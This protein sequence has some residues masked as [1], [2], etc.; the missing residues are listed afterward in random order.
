MRWKPREW[1][2]ELDLGNGWVFQ[3]YDDA[4]R[5][6]SLFKEDRLVAEGPAENKRR[7]MQHCRDIAR[8]LQ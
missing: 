7:A 2:R 4:P 8:G 6:W 3:M 5:Q 1:G